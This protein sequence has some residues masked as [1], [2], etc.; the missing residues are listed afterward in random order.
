MKKLRYLLR[1]YFYLDTFL[2]WW[3]I[4]DKLRFKKSG[5]TYVEKVIELNKIRETIRSN[6]DTHTL[7]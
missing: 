7:N 5:E 2:L 3:K 6:N 1:R 4:G